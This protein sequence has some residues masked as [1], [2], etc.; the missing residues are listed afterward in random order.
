[1]RQRSL[2]QKQHRDSV[3]GR[4]VRLLD[5]AVRDPETWRPILLK[6]GHFS[7]CKRQGW[8]RREERRG[9]R[10]KKKEG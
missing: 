8:R 6:R 10:K 1:M 9:R 2:K 7:D 4:S 5:R 3:G